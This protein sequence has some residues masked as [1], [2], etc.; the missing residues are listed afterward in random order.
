MFESSEEV[1]EDGGLEGACPGSPPA[2]GED[3]CQSVSPP[4]A[5]GGCCRDVPRWD[6]PWGPL[7]GGLDADLVTPLKKRRLVRESR[8]SL[9]SMTGGL[10]PATGE[11]AATLLSFQ[12]PCLAAPFAAPFHRV[13]S[14]GA[15]AP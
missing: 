2:A 3:S 11:A 9:D 15:R 13:S 12:A 8:E 1:T 5:G 4:P 14:P 10:S 7:R 6:E